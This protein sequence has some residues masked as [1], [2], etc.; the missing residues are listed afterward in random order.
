MILNK[1]GQIAEKCILAI[2]DHFPQTKLHQYIVMPNH[3]HF[4]IEIVV[5]ANNH[6]PSQCPHGT[7]RTIGSIIRGFKIG[8]TK[9]FRVHS[10]IQAVWQRNY[11]EH[12]IRSEKSFIEKSE[13]IQ[14]NALN[15]K[16]DR[17]FV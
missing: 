16:D 14:F 12:I 6:S 4:I 5:G 13:Y 1:S 7:S 15:W 3:I 9:W 2:P 8:V 11:Y 17:Y 10:Q